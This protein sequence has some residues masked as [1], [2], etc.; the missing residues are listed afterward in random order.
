MQGL[1]NGSQ[2]YDCQHDD[3]G[4]Q[5]TKPADTLHTPQS[6]VMRQHEQITAPTKH[7]IL[8]IK[9]TSKCEYLIIRLYRREPLN[10]VH[11]S[12][13]QALQ[14]WYVVACM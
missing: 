14:S 1:G 6:L 13:F 2:A 3:G 8:Y 7:E 4:Q 12:F 11:T 10:L 9:L 5:P